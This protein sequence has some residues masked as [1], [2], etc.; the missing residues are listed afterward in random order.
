MARIKGTDTAPELALRKLLWNRGLRY[1]LRVRVEGTR[2]DLT[3]AKQRVAVFIDGCFWHG[4]PLHYV[5]PRSRE[6]FWAT[7][8]RLNVLRDRAQTI[9]L[10]ASGWTILRFW[11]HQIACE[12]EHVADRIAQALSR[13]QIREDLICWVVTEVEA[14][15]EDGQLERRRLEDLRNPLIHRVE[16]RMRTTKKW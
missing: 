14:L 9:A 12:P 10:E 4:C 6:T 7:K 2:P 3:F 8:L 13:R 11:E 15:S 5:K 1:R 16:E